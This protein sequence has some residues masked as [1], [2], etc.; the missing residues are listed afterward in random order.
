MT[1]R[2]LPMTVAFRVNA[3][4]KKMIETA[5]RKKKETVSGLL[6]GIVLPYLEARAVQE[7]VTKDP[8]P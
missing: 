5:A 4:E 8:E 6:R 7:S 3:E 2:T 1:L